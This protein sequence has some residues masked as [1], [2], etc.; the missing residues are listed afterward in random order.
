M[1][2]SSIRSPHLIYPGQVLYLEKANGYARLSTQRQG[3]LE[4]VRLS[5]R[6]RSQS[7]SDLSLP[8][9]QMHVLE[10]FLTE[11]LVV[12]AHTLDQAPR[13]IAT[14]D[15]RV[16]LA[17]GDQ[18][19]V[20]GADDRPLLRESDTPR[21]WRVFRQ[22]VPLLDPATR[23]VLGYEAHYLGRA[24]LEQGETLA[25]SLPTS[26]QKQAAY[27]PATVRLSSAKEEIRSNDRL[28]AEPPRQFSS[29]VPHAPEQPLQA[30]VVSLYSSNAVRYGTE[31]QVVAI[32]KGEQ[33]GMAPGHV[34][35]LV[36]RGKQ[37]QDKTDP[38]RAEVQLPDQPN[39][40]AM[41]FRTFDRVSYALIMN[42]RR[43]VEVG[44]LLTNPN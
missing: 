38:Q 11:P 32:N 43:G 15:E 9:L 23:E 5:P 22:A 16:L 34:L 28:L 20:R 7:L 17:S 21:R 39:G 2:L 44:D 14:T 36:S 8:T 24:D 1:N 27:V 19:Y 31:H 13:I 6:T 33:D 25:E 10:P 29:Y 3:G 26:S 4:T 12:D 42:A 30:L 40:V 41:V 35:S 18:A 37:I